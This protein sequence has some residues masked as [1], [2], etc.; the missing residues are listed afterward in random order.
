[1]VKNPAS[2]PDA[3]MPLP[4]TISPSVFWEMFPAKNHYDSGKITDVSLFTYDT[5]RYRGILILEPIND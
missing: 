4:A 2:H 3:P 5:A 1:M